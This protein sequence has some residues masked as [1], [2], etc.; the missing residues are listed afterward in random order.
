MA[1]PGKKYRMTVIVDMDDGSQMVYCGITGEELVIETENTPDCISYQDFHST[2]ATPGPYS[3]QFT[4]RKMTESFE[5]RR[6]TSVISGPIIP[7]EKPVSDKE[8]LDIAKKIIK[9]FKE[10]K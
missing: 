6:Y 10:S 2:R 5:N 9:A 7:E 8:I 1:V 4:M 3:I